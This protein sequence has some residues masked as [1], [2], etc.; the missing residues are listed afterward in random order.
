MGARQRPAAARRPVV[1]VYHPF[2]A[3]AYARHIRAPRG[4]PLDLHVCGSP[5]DAEPVAGE[6]DVVYA[7][8]FPHALYPRAGRLR[9]FQAM[10]AGV[11]G[12]LGPGLPSRVVVTRVP[13]VFGPWMSEYV[14]GW[15]AWVTQ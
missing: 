5:A 10:A 6:A 12:V 15:C 13:G 9:W 11:D 8:Q 4:R 3:D 1:L 14:L 2:E 7:W